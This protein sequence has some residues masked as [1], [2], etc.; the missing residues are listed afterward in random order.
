MCELRDGVR[1]AFEALSRVGVGREAVGEGLDRDHASES[2][3]ARCVD[4]A[5]P[6]GAEGRNDF[7]RAEARA[8]CQRHPTAVDY[9]SLVTRELVCVGTRLSANIRR[10]NASSRCATSE[11]SP[12]PDLS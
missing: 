6:A 8:V 2:R 7:I 9:M 10:C 5:H 12:A 3:V 11:A 1:F 4:R